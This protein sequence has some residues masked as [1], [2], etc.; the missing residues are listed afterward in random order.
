MEQHFKA[1]NF[2]KALSFSH[3]PHYNSQD[4]LPSYGYKYP[5]P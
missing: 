1:P 5:S 3:S 4:S 2:V